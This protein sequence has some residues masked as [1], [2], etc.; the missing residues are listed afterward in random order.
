MKK[1]LGFTIKS[2][3]RQVR[4]LTSLRHLIRMLKTDMKKMVKKWNNVDSPQWVEHCL[5]VGPT[6]QHRL[7]LYGWQVGSLL[8]WREEAGHGD[9]EP[10]GFQPAGRPEVPAETHPIPVLILLDELLVG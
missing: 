6:A 5:A 9:H 10:C 3:L 7:V 8:K 4:S 1:N 2:I